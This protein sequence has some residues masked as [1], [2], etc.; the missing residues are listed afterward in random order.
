M[1]NTISVILT[2]LLT[3]TTLYAKKDTNNSVDLSSMNQFYYNK[4]Y[5]DGYKTGYAKGYRDAIKDVLRRL[6]KYNK[7]MKAIEAS[8]YLMANGYIT[9]PEIFRINK[10]GDYQIVITKPKIEKPLS[11]QD[12]I[13]LPS[14]NNVNDNEFSIMN[15]SVNS[16]KNNNDTSFHLQNEKYYLNAP[17][18]SV[19][20]L[21]YETCLTFPKLPLIK[22]ILEKSG[23]PFI[24]GANFYKIF[25]NNKR[26]LYSFCRNI[27]GN[28][29]K[30]YAK[31]Y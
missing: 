16:N 28:I 9:Y 7:K 8:K 15:N 31:N 23:K 22:N 6:A 20:S 10:D 14:L 29:C 21:N 1:K 30:E 19:K 27:G 24:E 3:I 17:V 2:G 18:K 11:I 12:L 25:F 4:G 26:E 5:N 13:L